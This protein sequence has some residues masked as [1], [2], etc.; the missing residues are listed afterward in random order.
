MRKNVLNQLI[1]FNF[2]PAKTH[3]C[4]NPFAIYFY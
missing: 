2:V 4:S 3:E 1:S